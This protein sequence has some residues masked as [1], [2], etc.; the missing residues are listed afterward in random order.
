[1]KNSSHYEKVTHVTTSLRE[2]D[3]EEVARV[4]VQHL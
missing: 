1:M 3:N 2:V 4:L